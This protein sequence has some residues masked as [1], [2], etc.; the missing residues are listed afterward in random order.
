MKV[1]HTNFLSPDLASWIIS[2][3]VLI[4]AVI[5]GMGT[6]VGGIIGAGLLVYLKEIL[7]SN[8]GHWYLFLGGIFIFVALVLPRGIVGTFLDWTDGRR[9]SKSAPA[10]TESET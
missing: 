9:A 4:I 3:D 2:G 5:G 7:S 1:Q 8:F 6:F 10:A